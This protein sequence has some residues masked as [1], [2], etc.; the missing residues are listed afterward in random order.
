M[1]A[2]SEAWL[3]FG[4]GVLKPWGKRPVFFFCVGAGSIAQVTLTLKKKKK[5]KKKAKM[6]SY[7]GQYSGGQQSVACCEDK[8]CITCFSQIILSVILLHRKEE[9]VDFC[10]QI[11][12]PQA[13]EDIAVQHG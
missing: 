11:V 13:R 12:L 10:C 8:F 6:N 3:G 7:L 5:K 9:H 2:D 1:T 4:S